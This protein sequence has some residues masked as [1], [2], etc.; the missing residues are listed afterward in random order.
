M[1][2]GIAYPLA[3]E[4]KEAIEKKRKEVIKQIGCKISQ[5]KF[6]RIIG[7]TLK[8]SIEAFKFQPRTNKNEIKKTK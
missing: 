5:P 4:V 2:T 1:K 3:P 7:P 6:T 8:R